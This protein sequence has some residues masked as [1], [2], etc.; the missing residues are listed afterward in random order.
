MYVKDGIVYKLINIEIDMAEPVFSGR[1]LYQDIAD[2]LIAHK[3]ST[4]Q[5]I[6][7]EYPGNDEIVNLVVH[8]S[9][10]ENPEMLRLSN[11]KKALDGLLD[12]YDYYSGIRI[13]IN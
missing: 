9:N 8:V 4:S 6:V 10:Q 7:D 5:P 2:R 3:I 1:K 13:S 11:V 12:N